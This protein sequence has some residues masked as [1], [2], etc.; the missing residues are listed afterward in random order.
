MEARSIDMS[1]LVLHAARSNKNTTFIFQN[2]IYNVYR[3]SL[4][5]HNRMQTDINTMI[6]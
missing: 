5:G 4:I 2:I 3:F 6:I 1:Y